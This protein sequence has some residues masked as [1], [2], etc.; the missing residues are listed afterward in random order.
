MKIV[1]G[2]GDVSYPGHVTIRLVKRNGLISW[3]YGYRIAQVDEYCVPSSIDRG[4]SARRCTASAI[5]GAGATDYFSLRDHAWTTVQ[6][7]RDQ[8]ASASRRSS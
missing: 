5:G 8:D 4:T 3:H 1:F 2:A 7:P 6:E